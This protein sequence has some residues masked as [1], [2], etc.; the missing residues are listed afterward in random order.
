MGM[1]ACYFLGW[2]FEAEVASD[3]PAPSARAVVRQVG[4]LLAPSR[5]PS[6]SQTGNWA[7]DLWKT[8]SEKLGWKSPPKASFS[9]CAK[10]WPGEELPS[11]TTKPLASVLGSQ[12]SARDA[13][14]EHIAIWGCVK[15][16]LDIYCIPSWN[17]GASFP[18]TSTVCPYPWLQPLP[19]MVVHR[20]E[21]SCFSSK[22]LSATSFRTLQNTTLYPIRLNYFPYDLSLL[23]SS[24]F[25]HQVQIWLVT[26]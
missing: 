15:V 21:R 23:K 4:S 10:R 12:A 5:L 26:F 24:H 20:D 25:P 18:P 1:K 6:P 9:V 2:L 17:T 8:G 14:Q 3:S 13:A 16:Y 7:R 11:F 19:Q 22:Q